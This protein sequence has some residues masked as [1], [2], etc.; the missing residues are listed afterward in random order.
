MGATL[1]SSVYSPAV[2]PISEEYHV[3]TEVS[4]LGLSLLLAGFGLGPLLWAPLSEIYG[5]KYAGALH[6]FRKK[7]QYVSH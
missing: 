4:L 5:R 2:D 3:G 7:A 1:N 6:T